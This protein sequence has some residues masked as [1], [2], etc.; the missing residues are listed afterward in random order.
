MAKNGNKNKNGKENSIGLKIETKHGIVAV[1]L[2]VFALFFLM[3]AFS[4]AGVAGEFTYEK[5]YY[6]L[7]VG[8]I[9]LPLLFILLG[10]SFLKSETPNL[11]WIR[12]I[13]GIFFLLAGLGMIDVASGA[14]N[15]GLLGEILSTPFISL[16]DVYASIIFLG[17]ILIISILVMFDAKLDLVSLFKN[18]WAIIKQALGSRQLGASETKEE[19]KK[20]DE[21]DGAEEEQKEEMETTGE[22]VKNILG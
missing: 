16:F 17:A 2:F 21:E 15:G 5:L 8:Y 3:S 4:V 20:T 22:K 18:I 12:I 10:S 19:D 11:G 9:L 6:L 13:S 7:G 14:H 1:I